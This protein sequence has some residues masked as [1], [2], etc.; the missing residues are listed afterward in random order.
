MDNIEDLKKRVDHLQYDVVNPLKEEVNNIKIELSNDAL[1]TKQSVE[2]NQKLSETMDTLKITMIEV[3][4][5]VKDTNK[6]TSQ[7]T[8][9]VANLNTKV[10][11]LETGTNKNIKE[12]NEKLDNIDDKSKVDI[13]SWI[14][15]NWFG[16]V[17][18]IGA[19]VYAISQML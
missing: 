15:N 10:T 2:T 3:A 19:L 12:L 16:A 4:Q 17:C 9:T 18:G 1:L 6:V 14:K 5:S 8:E 13:L 7:L 11:D